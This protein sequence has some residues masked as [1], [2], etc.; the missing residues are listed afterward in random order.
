MNEKK[1]IVLIAM[2]VITATILV[3]SAQ[4]VSADMPELKLPLEPGYKW[5]ITCCYDGTGG[6]I[7]AVTH[8]GKD[9]YAIDFNLLGEN[10]NGKSIRAVADGTAE[11][12]ENPKGYGYY[13]DIDHGDGY[14]SRYAHLKKGTTVSGYVL[15]G[16]EVGKCDK[17]GLAYGTHLHFVL[18]RKIDGQLTPVKPEPMSEYRD[19]KASSEQYL[20]SDNYEPTRIHPTGT[21]INSTDDKVYQIEN[22]QKRFIPT[23]NVSDSWNFKEEH[24]IT[25]SNK[26]IDQYP[27]GKQIVFREGT[28]IGDEATRERYVIEYN[29]K[30]LITSD[31]VFEQLGYKEENVKWLTDQSELDLCSDG[32]PII[33]QDGTVWHTRGTLIK[34]SAGNTYKVI[35]GQQKRRIFSGNV[36]DSRFGDWNRIINLS[37]LLNC[38]TYQYTT[39]PPAIDFPDGALILHGFDLYVISE[40]QKRHIEDSEI[41]D[42]LGYTW[43]PITV[44]DD[45]FNLHQ[46]GEDITK[47]NSVKYPYICVPGD[48]PTIQEA[49]DSAEEGDTI[50]VRDGT[51]IE[52]VKVNKRLTLIGEGEVIVQAADPDDNVFWIGYDVNI[53]GFIATGATGST[54]IG[55]AGFMLSGGIIN[56]NL[57][58]NMASGNYYGILFS[59]TGVSY[60]AG[61]TVSDNICGIYLRTGSRG[62]IISENIIKDNIG[63]GISLD[64]SGGNDIIGNTINNNG[65][66][67]ITFSWRSNSNRIASNIIKD[68]GAYGINI[69]PIA[70]GN[71][72]IENQ[73]IDNRHNFIASGFNNDIGTTNTVNGKP[74][75]FIKEASGITI[76]SSTNAGVVYCIECNDITVKDLVLEN[77]GHGVYFY[78]TDNSRIEN[79]IASNNGIGVEFHYSDNNI[80]TDS[81]INNGVIYILYSDGSRVIGNNIDGSASIA[82]SLYYSNNSQVKENIVRNADQGIYLLV[83]SHNDI[84]DNIIEDNTEYGVQV[85]HSEYNNIKRNIVSRNGDGIFFEHCHNSEIERNTASHNNN[86]IHLFVSNNNDVIENTIKNNNNYGIYF[87]YSS[88]NNLIAFN[89]FISNAN[90]AYSYGSVNTWNSP[91]QITYTYLGNTYT[92]YLGNYWDDYI[93]IDSNNDGIWDNPYSIDSDA[94]N[95]PLKQPFENYLPQES[96]SLSIKAFCPVNLCV[97]DPDNLIINPGTNEIPGASY[98]EADINGDGDPDDIISISDRKIGDYTIT[99]T[100]ELNAEPTDTYTLKVSAGDTTIVLADN[101]LISNI[102]AQPYMIESTDTGIEDKTPPAEPIPEFATIAIP[103][104]AILGLVFLFRRRRHKK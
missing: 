54:G 14:I 12:K 75:Y 71:H 93:D 72:F 45:E 30:R 13:V 84:L 82:V 89:N 36:F 59:N 27:E 79:V 15:Q 58:R 46:Q 83:A 16:T 21:L 49:I 85:S 78:K 1:S 74:I 88:R 32:E 25:L 96:S 3:F 68:N 35:G 50:I 99:V 44:N 20:I 62:N 52:N 42:I 33:W 65:G 48:Y 47:K 4:A 67:G 37:E 11:A 6:G 9:R 90:N 94:D 104:A 73:M 86:G 17:S 19:F 28:L 55:K 77:N 29:K 8:T 60:I 103:V 5:G 80:I 24:I 100:P 34:S 63:K 81:A 26:E 64:Y 91:E 39:V 66:T 22:N 18:Y 70:E 2:V 7:C 61:N 98:T 51:Y 40:N 95:Y 76:D 53:T 92:N 43:D 87:R 101:V 31:E 57:S 41:R 38:D 23:D 69:G 10:D 102:P 97:T 56:I